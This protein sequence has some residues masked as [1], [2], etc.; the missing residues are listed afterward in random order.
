MSKTYQSIPELLTEVKKLREEAKF[1]NDT[2]AAL[3]RACDG[4]FSDYCDDSKRGNEHLEWLYK[5]WD[6]MEAAT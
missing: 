2:V 3:H 5:K 4:D 1:L 6:A